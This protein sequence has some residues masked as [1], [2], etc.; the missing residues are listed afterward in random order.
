MKDRQLRSTWRLFVALS[1]AGAPSAAAA[2]AWTLDAGTGQLLV[3]TSASSASQAFDGARSLQSTPSYNKFE[4]GMLIEYGAAD[5]LT[6]MLLPSLQHVDIAPPVGAQRN[7]LGYTEFGGRAK[8]YDFDSWVLSMQATLRMPGTT[9]SS[10]PAGFGYTDRQE[11]VRVLLGHSFSI[12]TLPAFIDFQ[13]AQRFRGGGAPDE[14]RADF[15]FGIQP[16]SN[17]LLLAQSFNV[18]SEGAGSWGPPSYDYYKLQF[19]AVYQLTPAWALQFGAF[20][21]FMGRNAIQENGI[22]LGAW[23]RF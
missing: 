10:N 3:T 12:G 1:V 8:L 22:V 19:S 5:W 13:A 14:F 18:L 16:Q 6:L 4:P 20:T 7:G 2:G 21:T 23:Y 9:D 17:W 15:T 11:D